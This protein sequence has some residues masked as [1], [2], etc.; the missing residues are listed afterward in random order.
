[1]AW[2]EKEHAEN[3]NGGFVQKEMSC[4]GGRAGQKQWGELWA[5]GAGVRC[6]FCWLH[7]WGVLEQ[8]VDWSPCYCL[9]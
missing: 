1:M 7:C 5:E 8:E 3:R 4:W 2:L 6:Y 9:L